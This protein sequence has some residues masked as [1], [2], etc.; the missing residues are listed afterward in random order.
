[1][2]IIFVIYN[3]GPYLSIIPIV[4]EDVIYIQMILRTINKF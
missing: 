3:K 4:F 2:F 1:M